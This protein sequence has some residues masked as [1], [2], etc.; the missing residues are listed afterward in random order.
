MRINSTNKSAKYAALA[1]MIVVSG[2]F[3]VISCRS[4][5]PL[6][7]VRAWQFHKLDMPY[8][9]G[10]L[11]RA[12]DYDINTVV[13]S[14]GMTGEVSQLYDGTSRGEQLRQLADEAH[15]LGLRVWIWDPRAGI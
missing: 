4:A 10:V 13:F 9:S 8:V 12:A 11:K 1:A 7:P 2:A 5:E 3:L 15:E 14:H 6:V